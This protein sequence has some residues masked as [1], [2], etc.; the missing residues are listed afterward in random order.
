MSPPL[1]RQRPRRRFEVAKRPR[2]ERGPR[3]RVSASLEE[4]PRQRQPRRARATAHDPAPGDVLVRTSYA[5][6]N[7]ADVNVLEG[8]YGKLPE[9]PM[10]EFAMLEPGQR[11]VTKQL[12]ECNWAQIMEGD[13]DT[14]HFSFLHMPAPAMAATT[15]TH[16]TADEQRLRWMRDDPMPQFDLLEHDCGFV[17]A[18][19]R[20]ADDKKYWRMTQYLV[21][22]HGTVRLP[23][24][25][26]A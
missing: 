4:C 7:P 13:L 26:T 6:I 15:H 8:R 12:F 16:S 2:R 10:L 25:A 5:P 24:G 9:L 20:K 23:K 1:R 17:V 19:A 18:G 14:A 22:T 21:P 11:Y 3:C